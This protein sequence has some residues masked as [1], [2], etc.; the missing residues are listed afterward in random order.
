MQLT[1]FIHKEFKIMT[2]HV[3]SLNFMK[4]LFIKDVMKQ[5]LQLELTEA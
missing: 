3:T 2:D 5:S 4:Y 1:A